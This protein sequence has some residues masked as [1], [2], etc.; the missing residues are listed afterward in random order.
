M[1][2]KSRKISKKLFNKYRLII[3]NEDTF[4][5]R[6]SF[7]L[8]RLN[9]YVFGGIF[10]IILIVLTTFLI[11]FTPLREYIPGYSSTALKKKATKL[12]Y[13]L[14]SLQNAYQLN[15]TKLDAI[16][17]ILMGEVEYKSYEEHVDSVMNEI[18][19]TNPK[20][21]Y[22]SAAD[23]LFRQK[24]ENEDKYDVSLSLN[25]NIGIALFAPTSGTITNSFNSEE[26]HYAVDI[27]V[28]ENTP[29]KAIADGTVIFSEWSVDTGFVIIIDHGSSLLSVFKHNSQLYKSQGELVKMGEVIA[30]AGS[31]GHLS[32]GPHLHFELWYNGYP[33][34]PTEF[35]DFE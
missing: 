26:E 29:I 31:T 6:F 19:K 32:T 9:V 21:L 24:I 1:D 4:E 8:S 15:N 27:A 35:M 18:Q 7:T 10:V 25:N 14:D 16:T 2:K 23:S 28:K 22:A 17:K 5:E 20:E 3:V 30:T 11:A 33:L 12:T 34:D 13:E